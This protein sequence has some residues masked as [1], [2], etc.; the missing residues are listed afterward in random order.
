[1]T[2][3]DVIDATYGRATSFGRDV[4]HYVVTGTVFALVCSAAI[5]SRIPQISAVDLPPVAEPA[6]VQVALLGVVLVALFGAGHVLLAVGFCIRHCWLKTFAC[7]EHVVN[8][9]D[10]KKRIKALS[11]HRPTVDADR[12]AH[13]YPEMT[14]FVTRPE[15]HANFIERYNTLWHLRLGLAASM[16]FA[17]F[18]DIVIGFLRCELVPFVVGVVAVVLGLLLVRQHLV[19][20]TN[21]LDRIAAAFSVVKP[22]QR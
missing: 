1:M 6:S 14:V 13:V 17:G 20:N 18:I 16:L 3:R 12:N 4:F 10:A 8:Y 9:D 22:E 15:L 19:T 11:G 7:C 5:W 21:F 2:A